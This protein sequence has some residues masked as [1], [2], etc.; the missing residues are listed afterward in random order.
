MFR[1]KRGW[2][3]SEVGKVLVA[4]LLLAI[5]AFAVITLIKGDGGELLASIKDALRFGRA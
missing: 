3:M 1:G 4:I 5:L 2:E